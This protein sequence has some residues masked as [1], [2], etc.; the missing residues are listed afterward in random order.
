MQAMVDSLPFSL[1]ASNV[2]MD[3]L[4][5]SF[6]DDCGI[7]LLQ[8]PH[9]R[10]FSSGHH[11]AAVASSAHSRWVEILLLTSANGVD[12]TWVVMLLFYMLYTLL[13][14]C[15]EIREHHKAREATQ[16]VG[17]E[18]AVAGGIDVASPQSRTIGLDF[19]K[20]YL[21]FL[22]IN[23]HQF[24]TSPLSLP[25]LHVV[26]T[27][28]YMPGYDKLPMLPRSLYNPGDTTLMVGRAGQAFA[29][30]TF[31]FVSGLLGASVTRKSLAR[32]FAV[33]VVGG[34]FVYLLW[35][36][37]IANPLVAHGKHYT[38]KL[39]GAGEAWYLFSLLFWRFTITPLFHFARASSFP[40]GVVFAAVCCLSYLA[41]VNAQL[42]RFDFRIVP[43][44]TKATSVLAPFYAT[45]LL[46]TP[47]SFTSWV[48][49]L[50]PVVVAVCFFAAWYGGL[51][52]SGYPD[53][54]EAA[55]LE[56]S[57]CGTSGWY[58]SSM[59]KIAS[60][61]VS[62]ASAGIFFRMIALRLSLGLAVLCVVVNVGDT[63]HRW[64][65]AL[66]A[67]LAECGCRSLHAYLLHYWWLELLAS[68]GGLEWRTS[69]WQAL[70]QPV[71]GGVDIDRLMPWM[72]IISSVQCTFVFSCKMT[73]RLTDWALAPIW[74][75]ELPV[76]K[77]LLA[78]APGK[79]DSM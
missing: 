7:A 58:P 22:V 73:G 25:K 16:A 42:P 67:T 78:D 23:M 75:L 65:P 71:L 18:P 36:L 12:Q 53:W 68:P 77:G 1:G 61:G 10:I 59:S 57:H 6:T 32:I 15:Y 5:E 28:H 8:M 46:F 74:V 79:A 34:L 69:L 27:G 45:G 52:W 60:G 48:R 66:S 50:I 72:M 2:S 24:A 44:S 30:S 49:G 47:S 40:I 55:C 31:A 29:M 9:L 33:T 4:D 51:K 63:T 38:L 41:F 26:A 14:L 56:F 37:T 19:A 20:I 35:W 11:A 43:F 70:S 39:G 21:M 17:A 64:L 13:C 62:L 76:V 3:M 54:A